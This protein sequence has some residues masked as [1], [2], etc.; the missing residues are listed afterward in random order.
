MKEY[1]TPQLEKIEYKAEDVL[2]ISENSKKD[3]RNVDLS[4]IFIPS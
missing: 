3:N 1:M 4:D 2:T